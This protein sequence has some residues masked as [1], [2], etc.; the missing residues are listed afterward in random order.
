MSAAKP[1]SP[2]ASAGRSLAGSPAASGQQSKGPLLREERVVL[3]DATGGLNLVRE[4]LAEAETHLNTKLRPCLKDAALATAASRRKI[5]EL[6]QA[7][8]ILCRACTQ[9]AEEV[10]RLTKKQLAEIRQ[11]LRSPPEAVKRTLAAT[12]L[13]INSCRFK[14]KPVSAVRFDET[15]DWPRCQRML[16]DDGFTSSILSFDPTCLEE[17]P[18]VPLHVAS[19]YLGLLGEPKTKATESNAMP[20]GRPSAILRRAPTA[21]V[22]P[23]LEVSSVTRASEPCGSLLRWVQE[24]VMEHVER[25]RIQAAL[26]AYVAEAQDAEAKE[27]AAEADVAEAEAALQLL[28][29]GLAEQEAALEKLNQEKAAA[30]QAARDLKVLE[31]LMSQ[32]PAPEPKRKP[33]PAPEKQ[34]EK[35]EVD[36]SGT[37]AV[38][39]QSLARS[40]VPFERGSSAV[41]D[42]DARQALV[43]PKIAEIL[44]EHRGRLK[45]ELEGHCQE[46]EPEGT[47]LERSLAVYQ[48]LV[49]VAGCAPGLLRLK[50]C[51]SSAGLGCCSVPVP[52]QELVVRS[53][54]LPP[55]QEQLGS[56]HRGL[57]FAEASADLQ[58]ETIAVL[59]VMAKSILEDD[60]TVR[61]EG[62]AASNEDEAIAGQRATKTRDALRNLGVNRSKLRPQSCKSFH[63]LSRS[64]MAF[65]RRVELHVL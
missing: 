14:G 3:V 32:Q 54:P 20:R 13:L 51:G 27:A 48:W 60:C 29:A 34:F 9:A 38:V 10:G 41:L 24:L 25:T 17:A 57:F 49:Q 44:K 61:I 7:L 6:E 2:L 64:H 36:M 47:D 53:G 5:E 22:K 37:L 4:Q 19:Q 8:E 65:N 31:S 39:E 55:E 1:R 28:R 43:L 11:M 30:E 23:P 21:A 15:A 58:P 63:P 16:A 35:I 46:G 12:W 18:A 62:H 33:Q 26:Q 52:I 56:K 42:G 45:V 50:P 59:E 40:V